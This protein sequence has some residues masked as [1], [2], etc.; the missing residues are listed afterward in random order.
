MS[1]DFELPRVER[2]MQGVASQRETRNRARLRYRLRTGWDHSR[3]S[4]GIHK[5]FRLG[6][7]IFAS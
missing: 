1:S 4:C 2:V 7:K 3:V 6:D 5:K